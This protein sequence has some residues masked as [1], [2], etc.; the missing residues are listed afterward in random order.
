V[1]DIEETFRTPGQLIQSVLEE[2][3]WT[4]R[5]L[6]IVLGVD[7]TGI[8]KL[9]A[10]KR[11]LDAPLALSLESV[12]G[13]SAE[14]LLALQRD[15]DL[16]KARL[17]ER[18]D[19][20]RAVRAQ[21]FGDLPIAEMMKRGWIESDDIRNLR[22]VE[23]ELMKFF[24]TDSLD[25]IEILAHA[26]KKTVAD[27]TATPTQIAWLYRVRAL[28]SEM[29]AGRYAHASVLEAVTILSRFLAAP[30]EARNV[31]RILSECG[32]RFV[33]VETL[34]TAKIDGVCFW[35]DDS[36]P[37]VG[38]SMRYDRIDN[39]WFVLRHELEHVLRLHGRTHAKLD[40]ELEGKRAGTGDDISEEERVAN[41]AAADFC[42]P[43]RSMDSF[44][45]RKAPFF[46]ERDLLGF[47]KTLNVHP[48]LV[49]G[50]LAHRTGKY[51]RF[52]KYLVKMRS[53]VAPGAVVDGWGEVAPLDE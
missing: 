8:N 25:E 13:I 49:A 27:G 31:P 21:L 30:E 2:R 26:A 38:L 37:V 48:G 24:G 29:L 50:Q 33:I 52:R 22:R 46:A 44:V 53:I 17:T 43:K 40:Y 42:V 5:V 10:D 19:P 35:L 14:R 28:A 9:I 11:Q 7:E 32:I 47:A 6:A 18:P 51:E 12:L 1:S 20:R 23:S 4:Q 45:A 41:E 39:F 15:H 16:A 3:G 34:T 36:S